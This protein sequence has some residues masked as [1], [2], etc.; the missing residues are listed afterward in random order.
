MAFHSLTSDAS[1]IAAMSTQGEPGVLEH[2]Y[3][4]EPPE[5]GDAVAPLPGQAGIGDEQ[6]EAFVVADGRGGDA[7]SCGDLADGQQWF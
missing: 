1:R 4:H 6:A 5:G 3:E 2:A 7:R